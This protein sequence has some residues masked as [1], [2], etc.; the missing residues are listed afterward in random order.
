[1]NLLGSYIPFARTK[2]EREA[3]KDSR[4]SIQERYGDEGDYFARLRV[5][6]EELVKAR[7]RLQWEFVTGQTT[8]SS[9]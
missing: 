4:L 5:A 9:R 6:A 8:P 1:V 7:R 2:A 3:R